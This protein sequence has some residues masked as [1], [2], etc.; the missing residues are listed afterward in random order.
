[1]STIFFYLPPLSWI[2]RASDTGL[3]KMLTVREIKIDCL[4][5]DS[6]SICMLVVVCLI[7]RFKG[8]I[9]TAN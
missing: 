4:S 6:I 9:K 5:T 7:H 8:R 3:E 2:S 1:M